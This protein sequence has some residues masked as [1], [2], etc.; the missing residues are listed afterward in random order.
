MPKTGGAKI[1]NSPTLG[2]ISANVLWRT[3]GKREKCER[4]ERK[5][6]DKEKIEL[7]AVR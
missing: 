6:K 5:R 1:K 4:K 7:R 3:H 2:E